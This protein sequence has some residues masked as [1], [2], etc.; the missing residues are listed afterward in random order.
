MPLH[1]EQ[2]PIHQF[3][4]PRLQWVWSRKAMPRTAWWLF[5]IGFHY[6]ENPR[7]LHVVFAG[8][9]ITLTA[10]FGAITAYVTAAAVVFATW[11]RSE[12]NRV[13]YVDLLLPTH[14]AD[15]RAMRGSDL[16]AEGLVELK[17]ARYATALLLL[18]KGV[19]TNPS[20][21]RGRLELAKLFMRLGYLHRAR[22]YLEEGLAY[23]PISKSYYDLYFVLAGYMEDHEAILAAVPRL[24]VNAGPAMRRDLAGH[25][26]RALQA[27]GR[28]EELDALR[29][30]F[31]EKPL[32]SVEIAWAKAAVARGQ[33]E[34]ALAALGADPLLFGLTEERRDLEARAAL[35]AQNLA[36]ARQVLA[37]WLA[38]RPVD[39]APRRLEVLIAARSGSVA[40]LR[41]ALDRYFTFFGSNPTELAQ[42]FVQL[43]AADEWAVAEQARA[44]AR[45]VGAF[46]PL[47][48]MAY[49]EGLLKHGHFVA[50]ETELAAA[51]AAISAQNL[52]TG[53]WQE[54][55]RRILDAC[56][57]PVPT[58]ETLL[59]DFLTNERAS[60]AG[61]HLAL[62]AL[63]QS[64]AQET[65]RNVYSLAQ[66][67]YPGLNLREET[68]LKLEAAITAQRPA[69]AS[70]P[71][72][73]P[74]ATAPKTVAAANPPK[75]EPRPEPKAKPVAPRK[76]PGPPPTERMAKS[77][78]ARARTQVEAGQQ[79]EALAT[80][81]PLVRPELTAF[82]KD[83]LL[84][85]ARCHAELRNYDA[86][87][88]TM[89]L[90]LRDRPLGLVP[91]LR[92]LVENCRARGR[93]DSALIICREVVAAVP[94]AK[95]AAQMLRELEGELRSDPALPR[96]R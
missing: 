44:L 80:L 43:E 88:S 13:R 7:R 84:L 93:N 12:F 10:V 96:S 66:S 82:S 73:K 48:R 60:P 59:T 87:T 72:P 47:A 50:A 62:D 4:L 64:R 78:L 41:E 30:S 40:T 24:E 74:K 65:L 17:S 49:V 31:R 51:Q 79:T 45:E 71:T 22:Q 70:K 94:E 54:G 5:L 11:S 37:E 90:L 26:A 36:R 77:L 27:L 81:E 19:A 85:Q 6:R 92:R 14:W 9:A 55:M 21:L 15:A 8:K 89:W 58:T 83:V 28:F 57:K 16:V 29:A 35:A 53:S 91:E 25:R 61:F 56:V 38:D 39:A 76:D 69:L 42:L 34:L 20:E 86:L 75:R 18:S 23:P 33:P 68:R 1:A 67:R 95:W 2:S 63:A 46:P 3:K 32:V 52:F